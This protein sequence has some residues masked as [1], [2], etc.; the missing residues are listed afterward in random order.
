M[1]VLGPALEAP[2]V[3]ISAKTP[4]IARSTAS[5]SFATTLSRVTGF[6]RQWAMAVA[7]GV[8]LTSTGAIPIASAYAISNNIP[9]ALYELLV[10]GVLSSMFIPIFLERRQRDGQEGAFSFSNKL[11]SVSFVL[12]GLMALVGTFLPQPFVW[13]QTFTKTAAEAQLTIYLFRF[14][15]V[16][17]VFYGFCAI[18]TGILNSNRV[19]FAPAIAPLANNIVVIAVLLGVYLPL[20]ATRPDLAIVALGVGTT[21]GVVALFVFQLPALFKLGFR[22]RW[23]WDLADP[24]LRKMAR[25]MVPIV[26]F[27]LVNIIGLSFRNA[28]ATQAFPDGAAALLYAWM[29]YQLPYGVLAVAYITAVFPEL[30]DMA[31][32]VDWTPYKATFSRGLRVLSL[33]IMPMAA[34]LIA[35]ATPLVSL[36]VA[37]N[38]PR[39]AVP[40]IATILR[41][42]TVGLFSFSSYM[43]TIRAFHAMQDSLT[44]MYTNLFATAVQIALYWYLTGAGGLG[45]AGIPLADAIYLTVHWLTLLVILRGR[46]GA[47]GGRQVLWTYGRVALASA[48]GGAAAWG[49]T[50]AASRFG[51]HAVVS[52]GQLLVG[53]TIG[54]AVAYGGAALMR[55]D[56]VH[57]AAAMLKRLLGRIRPSADAA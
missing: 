27:T 5:M 17:I 44:P 7:L 50:V 15:A 37:G 56:E 53:G 26:V 4:S 30:A 28:F 2:E 41:L 52:I 24:S 23:S 18:T 45:L 14:F 20:H 3:P 34:M 55:V 11:L 33:L 6:V 49:V 16:Q 40:L 12:L 39:A 13:T 54:L 36:Y 25:K 9:N 38:F 8:A 42:W 21:L 22:F 29:W 48:A 1:E 43:L 10:G 19:F 31:A 47:F 51:T 57:D 46:L 35:L 32:R